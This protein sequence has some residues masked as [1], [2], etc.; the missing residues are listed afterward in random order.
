MKQQVRLLAK[1]GPNATG[2]SPFRSPL[3]EVLPSLR[4][5]TLFDG[6]LRRQRPGR[7][8]GGQTVV[9]CCSALPRLMAVVWRGSELLTPPDVLG[10]PLGHPVSPRPVWRQNRTPFWETCKLLGCCSRAKNIT[11][12]WNLAQRGIEVRGTMK[13][14]GSV[15]ARSCGSQQP[16]PKTADSQPVCP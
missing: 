1:I 8:R 12:W 5:P 10:T 4:T 6:S 11:R 13:R 9:A 16:R 3:F 15:C 7:G 2:L 14:C